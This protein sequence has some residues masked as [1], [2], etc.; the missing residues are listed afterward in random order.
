MWLVYTTFWKGHQLCDISMRFRPLPLSRKVYTCIDNRIL[1]TFSWAFCTNYKHPSSAHQPSQ[2]FPLKRGACSHWQDFWFNPPTPHA[3]G[4]HWQP[5]Y[6]DHM[7]K[8]KMC[9]D[10]RRFPVTGK[11]TPVIYLLMGEW[12]S[13]F[14]YMKET[15][16]CYSN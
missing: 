8:L 2:E 12:M 1:H 14:L 7:E 11:G 9:L 4:Y 3:Y 5:N 10:S 6:F 15:H 16:Y 13:S